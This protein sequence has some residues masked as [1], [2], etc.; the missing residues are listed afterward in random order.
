M[1]PQREWLTYEEL[2]LIAPA[3]PKY[4]QQFALGSILRNLWQHWLALMTKN[5]PQIS[6]TV[7]AK[8]QISWRIYD[9][10]TGRSTTCESEQEVR[11]WLDNYFRS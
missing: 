6:Q 9:P 8:G 5:E 3:N 2:E 10:R 1:A 7:D 4:Q 11:V